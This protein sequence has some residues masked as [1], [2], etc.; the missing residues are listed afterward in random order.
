MRR[1]T[2]LF[3]QKRHINCSRGQKK[4]KK[5]RRKSEGKSTN[6]LVFAFFIGGIFF[7]KN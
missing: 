3:L 4:K 7:K 2:R 1:P 5:G 6:T